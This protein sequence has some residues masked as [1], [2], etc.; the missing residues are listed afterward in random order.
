M[1]IALSVGRIIA[2]LVVVGGLIFPNPKLIGYAESPA[3]ITI[4]DVD[5]S[6]FP[7]MS[8][9]FTAADPAG[10]VTPDLSSAQLQVIENGK[11][12]QPRRL[13]IED[14]GIRL[15][16]AFNPGPGMALYAGGATRFNSIRKSLLESAASLSA[17]FDDYSLITSNGILTARD[18]NIKQWASAARAVFPQPHQTR[19]GV[20][21]LHPGAG[22]HRRDQSAS[23][24]AAGDSLDHSHAFRGTA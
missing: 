12:L 19:C 6:R 17:P 14:P 15:T 24:H 18:P 8:I 5:T 11:P 20:Q 2:S 1:N 22:S 21:Q 16:V 4:L 10:A 9:Y 23:A 13:A 3:Q 7:E